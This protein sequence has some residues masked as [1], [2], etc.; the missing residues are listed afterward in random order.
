[1]ANISS[2]FLEEKP[3]SDDIQSCLDRLVKAIN[4]ALTNHQKRIQ[5]FYKQNEIDADAQE[6]ILEEIESIRTTVYTLINMLENCDVK[7][8]KQLKEYENSINNVISNMIMGLVELIEIKLENG[9][10]QEL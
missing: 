7:S 3:T 10:N 6:Q 8:K 5:S 4:G 2:E 9:R 1:M